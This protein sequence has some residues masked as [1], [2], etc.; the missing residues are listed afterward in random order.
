MLDRMMESSEEQIAEVAKYG[1]RHQ[2]MVASRML[3]S[4]RHFRQ[5]EE[6]HCNLLRQVVDASGTEQQVR[7]VKRMALSMIHR[8]APFE[9]LRDRHV[10]GAARHRF[11]DVMYGPHDFAASVVNEHRNYLAACATYICVERFCAESSMRAI[12][13]YELCYTGYWRANTGRQL[14][15]QRSKK[16]T[17]TTSLLG[18]LRADLQRQ[19]DAVL[20]AAP[21]K[22]DALTIE[23]L[24]KPTGDTVR[25]R[26]LKL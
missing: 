26:H 8:K 18:Y 14:D 11:F 3:E 20:S 13:A 19:R 6:I 1:E 4:P 17:A 21:S 9:Y 23:E 22:A 7:Q 16:R 2:K 12:G 25:I 5:W 24:R 15:E 10:C